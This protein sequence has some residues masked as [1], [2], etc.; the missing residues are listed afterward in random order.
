ME[1][2]YK[3][4]TSL[5]VAEVADPSGETLRREI[6]H[7]GDV[8]AVLPYDPARRCALVIRIPRIPVIHAGGPQA[9]V[10]APAGI[11]EGE[12]A[13]ECARREA[14]EEVGVRLSELTPVARAFSTPGISTEVMHLF[15]APYSLADRVA[16]GGGVEGEFENI[17]VV[18][19]PL[20]ALA[21]A[22]D[23]CEIR[24]LKTL[25]MVMALRLRRPELF[26]G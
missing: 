1:T 9:L 4:W 23:A 16:E 13:L 18:E 2:A 10:E 11:I 24:D 14:L 17:T 21:A 3:G 5:L 22:A 6:E 12:G 25:A 19:T 15:I 20:A 26:D 8:A 7:H